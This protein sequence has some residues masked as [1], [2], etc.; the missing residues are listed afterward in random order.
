MIESCNHS[1]A[2]LCDKCQLK[3]STEINTIINNK[4]RQKIKDQ[5]L[6]RNDLDSTRKELAECRLT[7]KDLHDELQLNKTMLA[8]QCDLSREAETELEDLRGKVREWNLCCCKFAVTGT[9]EDHENMVNAANLL[10]AAVEKGEWTQ[11][12]TRPL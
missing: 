3:N 10:V 1:P 7:V 2:K 11:E 9:E 5:I 4:E 12:T 8:R 6:L